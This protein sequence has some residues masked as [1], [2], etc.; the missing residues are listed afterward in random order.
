MEKRGC[1]CHPVTVREGGRTDGDKKEE[2]ESER[3][4]DKTPGVELCLRP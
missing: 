3:R 2:G 4:L 1:D